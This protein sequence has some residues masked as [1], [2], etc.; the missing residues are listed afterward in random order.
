[1]TI[2]ALGALAGKFSNPVFHVLSIVFSGGWSWACFGF[3]V[4]S[5][6]RWKVESAWLASSAL[7]IGVIVYYLLKNLTPVVPIGMP[8]SSDPSG[9]NISSG[10]YVWGA[11]ALFFGA[12]MGLFGNLARISGIVGLPFRLLVPL[13]AFYETSWRLDVEA[14]SAGPVAANTW[15]MIHVAAVVAAAALVGYTVWRWC[16]SVRQPEGQG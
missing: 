12:P 6:R 14:A 3:L 9:S 2:G 16:H 4:G 11:V 5:L 13:I 15:G 7:A 1:M 8:A 10:I